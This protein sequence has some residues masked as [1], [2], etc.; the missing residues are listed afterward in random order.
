MGLIACS[1]VQMNSGLG[2]VDK[3]EPVSGGCDVNQAEEAFG[4]L[5]V[6]SC[7]GAVDF[8]VSEEAFDVITFL[9]ERPVMFDFDPAV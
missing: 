3:F 1:G 5:I 9:V 8:E 2:G 6:P 7:A 4:E